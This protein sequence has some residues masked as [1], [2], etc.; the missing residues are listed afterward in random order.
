MKFKK[1]IIYMI[2]NILCC[3]A[4]SA[5]AEEKKLI[6]LASDNIESISLDT[7]SNL[8]AFRQKLMP[9]SQRAQLTSLP[10]SS[11]DTIGFTQKFFNYYPYQLKR[12]WDQAIFSGKARR[13][14]QFDNKD[15]LLDFIKSNDNAIGYLII[16]KSALHQ[17]KEAYNVIAIIG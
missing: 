16:E 1:L 14:K 4:F 10:L 15:D 12:I 7:I 8:Y 11:E 9:N 6:I 17:V 13:P 5:L 3:C 2:F